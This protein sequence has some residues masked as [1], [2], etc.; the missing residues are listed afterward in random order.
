[1][2]EEVATPVEDKKER[3]A[4][5]K[6]LKKQ[7]KKEAAEAKAKKKAAEAAA[8]ALRKVRSLLPHFSPIFL[9]GYDSIQFRF[10]T[11][12]TIASFFAVKVC[13]QPPYLWR[14]T[15]SVS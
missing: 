14:M 6:A 5:E 4:K 9:R 2:K 8:E 11:A 12:A 3:E 13:P 10:S 1:M 7:R 15:N